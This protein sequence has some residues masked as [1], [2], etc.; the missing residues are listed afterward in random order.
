VRGGHTITLQQ[1]LENKPVRD[2]EQRYN[3]GHKEVGGAQ[4][5]RLEPETIALVERR[6]A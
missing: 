4:L 2:Q 1:K 3:D 5:T 6:R